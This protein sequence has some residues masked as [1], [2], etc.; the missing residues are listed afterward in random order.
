MYQS[1]FRLSSRPFAA[2]PNPEHYFPASSVERARESL[3][4]SIERAAGLAVVI[5]GVGT[6]KTLLC[7][8]IANHFSRELP[9][10]MLSSARICTRQTLLQTLLHRLGLP[11]RHQDEGELRLTLTDHVTGR[12]CPRGVLLVVD[13]ADR[14]PLELLEE[15]RV[16]TNLVQDGEPRVRLM[17]AGAPRLEERIAH[18]QLESLNQRVVSRLYLEH[19]TA[20]ETADYVRARITASGGSA[21][22]MFTDDALEVVYQATSGVPRLINQLCDHALILAAVGKHSQLDAAGIEE[23]WSD[24]QQLP[25]PSRTSDAPLVDEA[26]PDGVVEFGPLEEDE[27]DLD[28][29]PLDPAQQ[30][31]DIQ[32]NVELMRGAE[33]LEPAADASRVDQDRPEHD[34]GDGPATIAIGPHIFEEPAQVA[35]DGVDDTDFAQTSLDDTTTTGRQVEETTAQ[36]EEAELTIDQATNPFDEEFE[37]EVVIQQFASPSRLARRAEYQVASAYSQQLARK[38]TAGQP[39]LQPHPAA[40]TATVQAGDEGGF[41]TLSSYLTDDQAEVSDAEPTE[42]GQ[43]AASEDASAD[44]RTRRSDAPG[45][46]CVEANGPEI[47]VQIEQE[48]FDPAADPVMPELGTAAL[49]PDAESPV[50]QQVVVEEVAPDLFSPVVHAV[51][52]QDVTSS[53]VDVHQAP[54][55]EAYAPIEP[56]VERQ[57]T[58]EVACEPTDQ[59][60]SSATSADGNVPAKGKPKS[61][62]RLF[63]N[64]RS[65]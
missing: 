48:P 25:L 22:S 12:S 30:L 3:V 61:L 18:P 23:A 36:V 17:M 35:D 63:S 20:E 5:G 38:L 46:A 32:R 1:H 50:N 26:A 28:K 53:D 43:A 7:Q 14:L 58:L 54:S 59:V 6:G 45:K 34:E 60:A 37:E 40:A 31:D 57:T 42:L 29:P 27:A 47:I 65:G 13:E 24:L 64:M 51:H 49:I 2:A 55:A 52:S 8:L 11:F 10:C 44:G 39:R 41:Q 9:V 21:Q 56:I 19:F 62:S 16:I 33:P 15:L 4:M